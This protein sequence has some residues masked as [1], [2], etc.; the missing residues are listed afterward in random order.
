M[1]DGYHDVSRTS[2][3]ITVTLEREGRIS[4]T[5]EM[6]TN[7]IVL[8]WFLYVMDQTCNSLQN[9]VYHLPPLERTSPAALPLLELLMCQDGTPSKLSKDLLSNGLTR[10]LLFMHCRE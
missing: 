1:D 4:Q 6:R 5:F 10:D 9:K 2:P 7:K 8:V 3:T